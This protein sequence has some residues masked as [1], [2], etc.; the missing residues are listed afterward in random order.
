MGMAKG[1]DRSSTSSTSSSASSSSTSTGCMTLVDHNSEVVNIGIGCINSC[2]Q[3]VEVLGEGGD[4]ICAAV[5]Q[6]LVM[7]VRRDMLE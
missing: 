4:T 1:T 6:R 2:G 3:V 5:V 7:F